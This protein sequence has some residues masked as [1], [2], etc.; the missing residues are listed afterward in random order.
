MHLG[1]L[2]VDIGANTAGLMTALSVARTQTAAAGASM[3]AAV[4][5]SMSAIGTQMTAVG[6]SMSM[7]VTLPIIGVG[8]VAIKSGMEFEAA[9]SSVQAVSGATG[10]QMA[11]LEASVMKLGVSTKY[12]ATEATQGA[13]ALLKAGL[14]MEQVL[15][16]GLQGALD[17]AAA[18]EISVADAAEIASTALNAFK[19]DNMSVSDAANIL[20]GAA[21]ASATDVSSLRLSLSMVS[22]V[23]AGMGLSFEDTNATLALFANNGLKGSDAGTSLKT[24]LLNLQPQTAKQ[25]ELFQQLGITTADGA[26]QFFT[27]EGKMKSMAEVSEVLRSSLSGMTDQQRMATLE[28][29]FGTDAIRAANIL[30]KEGGEGINNMTAAMMGI[31]A[32]DVA[33]TRL[34]NLK[35]AM[36]RLKGTFETV[37]VQLYESIKAPLAAIVEAITKAVAAFGNLSPAAMGVIAVIA[38]IAAAIGPLIAVFGILAQSVTAIAGLFGSGGVLAGI[39]TVLSSVLGPIALVIAAVVAIGVTI[40]AL[41][42]TSEGF[43][44]AIMGAFNDIKNAIQQASDAIAGMFGGG[45]GFEGMLNALK[46]VWNF[47]VVVFTPAWLGI[48]TVVGGVVSFVVGIVSGIVQA[49]TGVIVKIREWWEAFK[50]SEQG[51]AI[52]LKLQGAWDAIKAKV[53][54]LKEKFQPVM[55][56]IME[57]AAAV[58]GL[59]GKIAGIAVLTV[60]LAP[61]IVVLGVI[62]G[63]VLAVIGVFE[64]LQWCW[65]A[66]KTAAS[67]IGEAFSAAFDAV[68]SAAASI[69]DRVVGVVGPLV[70]AVANFWTT[71]Y[72]QA[73]QIWGLIIQI[74][75]QKTGQIYDKAKANLMKLV[76]GVQQIWDEI[77]A[78]VGAA[79]DAIKAAVMAKVTALIAPVVNAITPIISGISNKFEEIKGKV[80]QVWEDIKSAASTAWE[81]VRDNVL[82]PLSELPGKM[83]ELGQQIIQGI[84]DGIT[85]MVGALTSKV[86]DV[87]DMVVSGLS[88]AL[89]VRSPSRKTYEIGQYVVQGLA[90]GIYDAAPEADE[91]A[92]KLGER[93]TRATEA[94]KKGV[95]AIFAEMD[96]TL[97]SALARIDVAIARL[98]IAPG[99]S[100]NARAT[101]KVNAELEKL[102]LQAA[103][104]TERQLSLTEAMKAQAQITGEASKEYEDLAAQLE[105]ARNEGEMLTIEVEKQNVELQK[106]ADTYQTDLNSAIKEASDLETEI[107]NKEKELNDERIKATKDYADKKLALEKKLADDIAAVYA[108]AATKEAAIIKAGLDA[109]TKALE[110]YEKAVDS[111]QSS[112]YSW[113]GLFDAAGSGDTASGDVLLAN[114]QGQ[115]SA[116]DRW[117]QNITELSAKGID[118]G[119]LEELRAMGPK[120]GAQIE[121]LNLMTSEKLTQYQALWKQKNEQ[122]RK[123][124]AASLEGQRLEMVAKLQEI[125][126]NTQFELAAQQRET[127]EKLVAIQVTHSEELAKI[128]EDWKKTSETIRKNTEDAIRDITD[129]FQGLAERGTEFAATL[130]SNFNFQSFVSFQATRDA[131]AAYMDELYSIGSGGRTTGSSAGVAAGGSLP[132]FD[133]G[134]FITRTGAALIHAGEIVL[135]TKAVA[136]LTSLISSLGQMTPAMAAAG[137]TTNYIT[138]NS[139]DTAAIMR[140]LRRLGVK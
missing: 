51:V 94:L 27:A 14:S 57:I 96:K 139:N 110:D 19:A 26:N 80:D 43:R 95:D 64:A 98:D 101:A 114:L 113:T 104:N 123:E 76:T 112:L 39:G 134:G 29:M 55:D 47:L 49:I 116:F 87:A 67:A 24:M 71:I 119:L 88:R 9:M 13:E 111:K 2:V 6:R 68:A 63:A 18:G 37:S 58:G 69:Y 93:V 75:V 72:N 62:V 73:S 66:L 10:E 128:E 118:E 100:E 25:K 92:T 4:G 115:V 61:I 129:K 126:A 28:M 34:D 130:W 21:N 108:D 44:N 50:Q 35:G 99:M 54:E 41:W 124:A 133:T 30:Y 31:S 83:I 105:T 137:G 140:E 17:L 74:I 32:A 38:G 60:I 42:D 16:G 36:A 86:N 40:K 8:A 109:E 132:S 15:G 102:S 120:S 135:N 91:A 7:L 107:A 122:T 52:L 48:K 11:Q 45:N 82:K 85:N 3:Q 56:K 53:E 12:G 65:E 106:L 46:G 77:E 136:A 78:A 127:Q 59:I 90:N 23:A 117:Q 81:G 89:E 22:S 125:R 97:Q 121:A 70:S 5:A 79:W 131:L 33:A 103:A 1:N 84:I 20:A 138:I